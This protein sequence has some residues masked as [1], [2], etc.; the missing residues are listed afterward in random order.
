MEELNNVL[1]DFLNDI[2]TTFPEYKETLDCHLRK[3]LDDEVDEET[4]TYL[5]DHFQKVYPERFFD[6]LYQK[7]E[8]FTDADINTEFLP[9]IHFN[10]LW[11]E[12]ISDKTKE[13]IWKYLQLVLFN[14]V[15][16][17][18]TNDSFGDTAKLFEA[19]NQDELHDKLKETM[20]EMGSFFENDINLE[21][22]PD[23]DNIHNHLN[24]M[25]DGNLGKLAREIAE[26]TAADLNLDLDEASSVNDVFEKL[27]KNPTKLMGLVGN[28]GS[29]LDSKLKSGDLKESDMIKEASEIL[30]KMKN[31]PGMNNVQQLLSQMGGGGIPG[32]NMPNVPK[33]K[34][35]NKKASVNT[36]QSQL[37]KNLRQSQQR[38]RMLKKL[39]ARRKA[40]EGN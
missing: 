10:S 20:N 8:I 18:K 6:I 4:K 39:E 5:L 16:T 14:I 19:I 26:E 24:T 11:N 27:F 35:K 36:M 12:N 7:P 40:K 13:V 30:D 9:G 17:L 23:A 31:M 37:E 1:R 38:E 34:P 33:P 21:N 28:V 22:M 2:L 25:L 32:M 29:K 3:V 15:G